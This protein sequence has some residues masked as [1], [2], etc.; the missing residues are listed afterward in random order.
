M[1]MDKPRLPR[2]DWG[3]WVALIV[4]I[5]FV[6]ILILTLLGP[7]IGNT[8]S[9]VVSAYPGPSGVGAETAPPAPESVA[10][11]DT[12]QAAS[13]PSGEQLIIKTGEI[14]ML[15]ED[16]PRSVGQVT[17]I[18]TDNGGYVL[19]SQSWQDGELASATIT[20]AVRSE[21]FETAMRRLRELALEVQRESASG[22]DVSAEYV[23]LASRLRN[24]EATRGRLR[25]FMDQAQTV[26]EALEVNSELAEIEGEIEQVKGRMQYLEGRA[27]YSTITIHL[28][29]PPV[30]APTPTPSPWSLAPTVNQAAKAQIGALRWL[31][32]A[33]V[34]L[35][36]VAAPYAIVIGGAVFGIR[37]W[38]RRR[39]PKPLSP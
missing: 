30:A 27:A 35:A 4:P 25:A 31:M 12:A 1:I 24:L 23:D 11:P 32:Q 29:N 20:I 33:G 19:S 10:V 2:L 8:F 7:T 18:A 36:V 21:N 26:E 28:S 13:P 5:L 22:E 17:Q 14:T 6:I 37:S 15:V 39:T 38:L 9:N 3:T 16:T 34:W